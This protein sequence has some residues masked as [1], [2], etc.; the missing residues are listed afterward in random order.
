LALLIVLPAVCCVNYTAS[1][2]AIAEGNPLPW[3]KPPAVN[4]NVVLTAEGNPLPWPKPPKVSLV[5]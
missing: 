4:N 5:A 1:K 3:P 2:P